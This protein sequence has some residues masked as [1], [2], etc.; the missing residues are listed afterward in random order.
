MGRFTLRKIK[1]FDYKRPD[2]R[3]GYAN[4][5]LYVNLSDSDIAIKPVTEEMKE[6][7]VGGKGFDL[8]LLWHAVRSS[9]GGTTRRTQSASPP[10]PWAE[11]PFILGP[12]KASSPPSR[13]RPAP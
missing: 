1:R 7:F 9:R 5:T 10:A 4:R 11:R 3:N 6:T 2:I 8:W 12:A 13:R